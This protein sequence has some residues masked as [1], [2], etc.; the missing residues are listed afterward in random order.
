MSVPHIRYSTSPTANAF[1]IVRYGA[2]TSD[3]GVA[4]GILRIDVAMP[5]LGH[6]GGDREVWSADC[7]VQHDTIGPLHLVRSADFMFGALKVDSTLPLEQASHDS[8]QMILGVLAAQGYP[9]PLRMWNYLPRI[10]GHDSG[11]ERYQL[12]CSGRHLAFNTAPGYEARLPAASALGSRGPGMVVYFLA[13]RAAGIQVENPQQISAFHYPRQYGAR[14]PSFSRAVIMPWAG[15]THFYLSGT[16]SVRGHTSLHRADSPAQLQLTLDNIERLLAHGR[17][18][19]PSAPAGLA[20]L[21][22]LKVYV[23]R[24]A[25]YPYLRAELERRL[26]ADQAVLYLQADVCRT[27]LLLEI[28]G[29]GVS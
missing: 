16:A 21:Q 15:R 17:T 13:A 23:R 24:R 8:Y 19:H 22:L 25:D 6:S 10:V 18:L 1:A 4:D 9:A 5:V 2:A 11:S 7:P 3:V 27:E 12:F 28:E 20:A 14:S 26:G 29:I